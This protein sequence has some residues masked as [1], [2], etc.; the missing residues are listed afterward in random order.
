MANAGLNSNGKDPDRSVDAVVRDTSG[1]A[2]AGRFAEWLA[3]PAGNRLLGLE[4]PVVHETVR[5]FHGDALLWVGCSPRLLDTTAQCMVRS[6]ILVTTG[7]TPCRSLSREVGSV[8]PDAVVVADPVELPL[9]SRSVDGIVL[10]H[11]LDLARDRRGTLREAVRVLRSGGKLV[12]LGFNP[13]SLWLFSKPLAAF[14]D[15]RPLSVPRLH[16]WLTVL[17]LEREART[18]YLNYRSV[19]PIVDRWRTATWLN[20]V[21]LPFGGVYIFVARK[22]GHGVIL[23]PRRQRRADRELASLAVPTATRRA[24]A[25]P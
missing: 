8:R 1:A 21:H 16:D 2:I 18:V 9:A 5:R 4:R 3:T 25:A 24:H 7:T 17:G 20:G 22:H 6:R 10:H 19:L 23:Q 13:L 15:L 11:T 14:R 12:V